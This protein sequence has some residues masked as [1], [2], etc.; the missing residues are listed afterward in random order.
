MSGSNVTIFGL[1]TSSTNPVNGDR[2]PAW[3]TTA[4]QTVQFLASQVTAFV[5]STNVA[6]TGQTTATGT[7]TGIVSYF[8]SSPAGFVT[9]S[10]NGSSF[11]LPFYNP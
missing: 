2:L 3:Q 1:A 5:F 9:V 6:L 10:I 11:K 8:A 4:L 7:A